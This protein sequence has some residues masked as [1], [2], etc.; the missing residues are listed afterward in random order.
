MD[1]VG[2]KSS[3][4]GMDACAVG[5]TT[6]DVFDLDRA[7]VQDYER[8]ARSFTQIRATDIR[9]QVEAIYASRRFW[10]DPLV[11]INPNF[12][13]DIAIDT[14]VADGSLHPSTGQV[15]RNSWPTNHSL[16]PPIAGCAPQNYSDGGQ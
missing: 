13:R 4:A 12:E 11:S 6:I 8:F 10:P 2:V 5:V 16:S 3:A 7:L 9:A 14:L 1:Y 15:F